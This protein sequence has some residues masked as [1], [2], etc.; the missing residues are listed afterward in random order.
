MAIKKLPSTGDAPR[1]TGVPDSLV[2]GGD[3]D[4]AGFPWEGRTFDHHG[5][6]F[7]NDDG[8]APEALTR[9]IQRVRHA[10]RGFAEAAPGAQ[11]AALAEL[12]EAHAEA[13]ATLAE[14]RLLIPLLAEAG[15][16][17]VTPE[18]R[19]VEKS[20][21][22][23]IVTV[24]GPDGRR[25]MPAFSSTEAMRQWNAEARPIPVPGP[26]LALAAAQEETDLIIID[27]GNPE[28]EFGVRRPAIRAMA[29]GERILPAWADPVVRGAFAAVSVDDALE[30]IALMPGDPE[31]R[32]LQPETEVHLLLAA[33]TSE[34]ELQRLLEEL[35]RR[36]AAQETIAARVDS[37]RVRPAGL[38]G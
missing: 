4:S 25:V 32:L 18:G 9:A 2:P 36:W 23:S 3:A 17:G 27:P 14:V 21:E 37:M 30:A 26:Q 12:G 11:P 8:S 7:E 35:Q 20:Q 24:A 15:D 34:V 10:A 28:R 16:V 22:L 38:R 19:T 5:T 29:L 33:G 31:G 1:A 6:A 13:V